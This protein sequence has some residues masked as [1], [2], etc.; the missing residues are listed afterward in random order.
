MGARSVG[1]RSPSEKIVIIR[2]VGARSVGA[3]SPSEEIAIIRSQSELL[4]GQG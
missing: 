2:S 3:R 1:A 4:Q